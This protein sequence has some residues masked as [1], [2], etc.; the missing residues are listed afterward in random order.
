MLYFEKKAHF[1]MARQKL[2]GLL[3]NRAYFMLRVLFRRIKITQSLEKKELI[4]F[5]CTVLIRKDRNL[6]AC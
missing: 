4:E 1:N 6:M 5:I 2:Y 3:E